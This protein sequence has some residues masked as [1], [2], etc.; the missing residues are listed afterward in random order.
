M[1]WIIYAIIAISLMGTSDLFRK[2]ASNGLK[3][4]SYAN[5]V[6]QIGTFLFAIGAFFLTSRKFVYEPKSMAFALIGGVLI[7]AF[8]L[9]SFKALAVGPG[10]STVMPVLR[11]GGILL[12]AVLGIIILKEHFS[13]QKFFGILLAIVGLYLLFSSK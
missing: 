6:F 5:F 4:A 10:V 7:S 13:I 8:T 3:D 2:L 11:I 1:S 12:V 9:V